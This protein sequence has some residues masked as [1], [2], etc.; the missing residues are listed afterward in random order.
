MHPDQFV[1]INAIKPDIIDR[2]IKELQWH[3]TFLDAMS[4]PRWAKVQIHIGGLYGDRDAAIARFIDTYR[5]LPQCIRKRLVIE[6]DDRLFAIDDCMRVHQSIGIPVVFDNLHQACLGGKLSFAD[7]L[8][9]A[10]STWLTRDG[11]LMVDYSSQAPGQRNGRHAEH[12]DRN[13][14]TSFLKSLNGLEC[15]IMLEIK[16]KESSALE[17]VAAAKNS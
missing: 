1:L 2:S 10:A 16:D 11:A 9:Q 13:D 6:N 17:A 3:C 4:L 15:D 8:R 12:I 14:F 5:Q 7:A